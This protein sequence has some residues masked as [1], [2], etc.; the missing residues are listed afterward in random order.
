MKVELVHTP[1]GCTLRCATPPH[2]EWV[3]DFTLPAYQQRLRQRGRKT[4][5]LAKAMGLHKQTT[6]RV[7]DMTAG[8]GKDAY[9]LAYCGAH[10]TLIERHPL[11]AEC[12][13]HAVKQLASHPDFASVAERMKVVHADALDYL[14]TANDHSLD[15]AYYDPMFP[16]RKKSALVKKDMQILQALHGDDMSQQPII[17][18]TLSKIPKLVI[19][20]PVGAEFIEGIKPHHQIIAS[21]IRY[22]VYNKTNLRIKNL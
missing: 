1:Q 5:P 8:L 16:K 13:T 6:L 9:W 17:H 10:V 14:Q 15:V 19:K 7:L 22:D 3:I 2:M 20:R 12:L 18:A 21:T 4:D 11:L